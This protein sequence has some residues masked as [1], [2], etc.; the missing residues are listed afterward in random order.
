MEPI[1]F[2]HL[3]FPS[4]IRP[5]NRENPNFANTVQSYAFAPVMLSLTTMRPDGTL[6]NP[7]K[8]K[9]DIARLKSAGVDGF[10]FSVKNFQQ[11]FR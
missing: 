4:S 11:L 10:V 2:I 7:D 6:N 1:L 8:L 5:L 9:N 3:T